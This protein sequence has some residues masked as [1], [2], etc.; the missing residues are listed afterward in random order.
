M[1]Q[2]GDL[3]LIESSHSYTEF[4]TQAPAFL[5]Y[6]RPVHYSMNHERE[7]GAVSNATGYHMYYKSSATHK[8]TKPAQTSM[9]ALLTQ[10]L[11]SISVI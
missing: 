11:C 2:L 8:P 1:L 6:A 10:M 4:A 7:K 3:F 9:L 5:V